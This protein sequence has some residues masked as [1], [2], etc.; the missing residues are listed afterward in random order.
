MGS[1]YS[2]ARHIGPTIGKVKDVHLGQDDIFNATACPPGMGE[3]YHGMTTL[4]FVFEID[5]SVKE[6]AEVEFPVWWDHSLYNRTVTAV[7]L[8][9]PDPTCEG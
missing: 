1:E 8:R 5:E 2:R 6:S 3:P 9:F 4:A 7:W